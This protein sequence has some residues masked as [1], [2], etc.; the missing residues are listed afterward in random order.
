MIIPVRC[1]TCNKVIGDKWTAYVRLVEENDNNSPSNV[2]FNQVILDKIP[3][4]A[5]FQA[6]EALNIKRMCCRRHF[7]TTVDLMEKI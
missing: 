7:L 5:E 2:T 3:C 1:F 6:M 4:T